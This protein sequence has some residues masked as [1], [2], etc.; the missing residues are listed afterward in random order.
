MIYTQP[1][2]TNSSDT[3]I[4]HADSVLATPESAGLCDADTCLQTH[5]HT[6]CTTRRFPWANRYLALGGKEEASLR[7]TTMISLPDTLPPLGVP[8]QYLFLFLPLSIYP[9]PPPLLPLA[10]ITGCLSAV[11]FT[12]PLSSPFFPPPVTF[13]IPVV[14]VSLPPSSRSSFIGGGV[15]NDSS[16]HPTTTA[17]TPGA[18]GSSAGA[19]LPC[20]SRLCARVT[21][22]TVKH[23]GGARDTTTSVI[24]QS[25]LAPFAIYL[26]DATRAKREGEEERERVCEKRVRKE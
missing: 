24:C 13:A 6:H 15:W 26:P 2:E 5:T 12:L 19:C 7:Q 3:L 14:S 25:D 1:A 4:K 10:S 22:R 9:R 11:R 21:H 16:C 8:L 20:I 23:V 18:G 17:T